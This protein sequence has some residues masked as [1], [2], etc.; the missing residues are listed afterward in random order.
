M[1][2]HLASA[3]TIFDSALRKWGGACFPVRCFDVQDS[4]SLPDNLRR[5]A[6]IKD[7]GSN[8]DGFKEDWGGIR[9]SIPYSGLESGT[10]FC[11][12]PPKEI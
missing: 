11:E 8:V 3:F 7:T 2:F 10:P 4:Y 1:V 6:R 5:E 12:D 9:H